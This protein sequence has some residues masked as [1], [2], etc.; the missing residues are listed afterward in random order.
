MSLT[1]EEL[2]PNSTRA[3]LSQNF[4]LIKPQS[5]TDTKHYIFKT[6]FLV[7][8]G[9]CGLIGCFETDSAMS[10]NAVSKKEMC[11]VIKQKYITSNRLNIDNCILLI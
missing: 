9:L 1:R 2:L 6:I 10:G 11:L 7:S 5:H 3:R 8:S 4:K